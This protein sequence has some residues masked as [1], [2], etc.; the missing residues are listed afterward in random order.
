MAR[1]H[2]HGREL[3]RVS[4]TKT[5][6]A[7]SEESVGYGITWTRATRAVFEDRTVLE[8]NEVKY[9]RDGFRTPGRWTV[10]G[11]LKPESTVET[12]KAF[13]LERGWT[14]EHYG[15]NALKSHWDLDHQRMVKARYSL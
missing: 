2:C 13:Y 8:K 14:E 7:L 1:L 11:R 15:P 9:A 10:R 5:G 3:L 6:D 4:K 12:I